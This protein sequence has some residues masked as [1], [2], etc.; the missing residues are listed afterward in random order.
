M[1]FEMDYVCWLRRIQQAFGNDNI[2]NSRVIYTAEGVEEV[3][4]KHRLRAEKPLLK[5]KSQTT[6]GRI[7]A[8]Q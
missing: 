8:A 6:P 1:F 2:N 5:H 3:S 7:S 4:W